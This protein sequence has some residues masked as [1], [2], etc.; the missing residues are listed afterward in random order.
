[1]PGL[2][3]KYHLETS[4]PLT[5]VTGNAAASPV[6]PQRPSGASLDG[7]VQLTGADGPASITPGETLTVTLYWA[8]QAPMGEDYHAYVH[9]ENAAGE[10]VAGSDQRPGGAYYPTSAWQPGD[11]LVD[12]HAV[13][14][15]AVLP[16]GTYRLKAGMYAYP[17]RAPPGRR[18]YGDVC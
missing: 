18:Q 12:V 7:K 16:A 9:L 3:V 13:E 10:R 14:I 4:G 17:S 15:P 11:N 8:P 1:M 6:Q 5:Q 2:D